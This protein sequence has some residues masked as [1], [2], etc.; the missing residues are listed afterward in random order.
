MTVKEAYAIFLNKMPEMKAI[1][2]F[3]YDSIY[4]F[5]FL[6]KNSK[7]SDETDDTLD[8]TASVD[9]RSRE[10]RAFQ[11]FDISIEEYRNGKEITN[12]S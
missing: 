10:V 1:R 8:C 11:P 2:C 7:K 3:E 9:K 4:V 5:Q 6:P 12:F